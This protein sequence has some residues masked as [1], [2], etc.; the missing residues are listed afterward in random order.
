MICTIFFVEA[1]KISEPSVDASYNEGSPV[2]I[3]CSATGTPDPDVK[4]VTGNGQ[5]KSL[6][7]K[8]ALLTFNSIHRTDDGQYICKANNSAGKTEESVTLVVNCK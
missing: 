1:P 7:K 3:G 4:W 6:G 5:T 8:S 2:S